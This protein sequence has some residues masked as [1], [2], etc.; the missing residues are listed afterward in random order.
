M[1]NKNGVA[2]VDTKQMEEMRQAV[3]EQELSA[4]SWVAMKEKMEATIAIHNLNDEYE[5]VVA[6]NQ[7]KLDKQR[8]EMNNR[9]EEMQGAMKEAGAEI[10]DPSVQVVE[11]N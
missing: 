2:N 10:V 9:F 1:A 7:E 4:R 8:E 5:K 3:V 11:Q 6:Y